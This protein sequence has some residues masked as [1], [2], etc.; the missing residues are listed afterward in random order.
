MLEQVMRHIRN[1]FVL[2]GGIHENTY[3]IEGGGISL[4]FLDD[5][6][7][8]RICGSIFNDG[9]YQYPASGLID[10]RFTGTVWVLAVP[11]SFLDVVGEIEAYEKQT[12]GA[13]S[14]YLS[15]SFAGYSYTRVTNSQTGQVATWKEIFRSRLNEWRKL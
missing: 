3:A 1:Y 12:G 13:S 6:Q 2:P 9:V 7:Y 14:P 15:E 4:P 11:R 10:E 5:G 8:F